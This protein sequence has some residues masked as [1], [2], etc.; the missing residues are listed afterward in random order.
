L[1]GQFVAFH[2]IYSFLTKD[3]FLMERR[4]IFCNT[5]VAF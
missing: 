3:R 2:C 5:F 4:M 1:S